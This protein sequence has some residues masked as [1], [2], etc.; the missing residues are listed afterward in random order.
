MHQRGPAT[1]DKAEHGSALQVRPAEGAD[2]DPLADLFNQ[3]RCFYRQPPDQNRARAFLEER[4]A[5][6]DSMVLVAE[7]ARPGL[8]GFTQLY[9]SLCSV[10][11][12]PIFVLYDLF[13]A[14]HARRCGVGRALLESA[15]AHAR[16]TGAVRIDLAT[17]RDN[18]PAQSLYRALGWVQDELFLHYA[19]NLEQPTKP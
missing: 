17:A 2:L 11:A 13:V 16:A 12:G 14:P 9:P 19:L 1:A 7:I 4:L 3:Y 6:G 10:A 15:I 18:A 5:R 8:L